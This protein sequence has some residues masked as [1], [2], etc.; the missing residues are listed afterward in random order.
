MDT[1]KPEFKGYTDSNGVNTPIPENLKPLTKVCKCCGKELPISA[2]QR[3]TN[4]YR[5]VCNECRNA[6]NG[7]SPR[8][9]D[10]ASNELIQELRARGYRGELTFTK[11]T[12]V[13]I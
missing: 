7:V 9:K 5:S 3:Y 2:F 4:G 11:V 6:N 1:P 12:K 8:F 13:V 10:F